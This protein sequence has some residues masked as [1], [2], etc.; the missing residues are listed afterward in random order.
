MDVKQLEYITTI[1]REE[2]ITKAAAK[3]FITQS[4]LNQQLLKL[5]KELGTPLFIRGRNFCYP[6]EAG[7][8]YLKGAREI[9]TIKENTYH[10]LDDLV[11]NRKSLLRVGFTPTRGIDMF[12]KVYPNFH[13]NHVNVTVYP[14]EMSVKEQH[15]GLRS[16]TL[17][18]A[19][20]T[21]TPK[22]YHSSI[23]YQEIMDEEIYLAIPRRHPLA[24]SY[25]EN[26]ENLPTLDLAKVK[27]EPFVLLHQDSTQRPLL[28]ELFAKADF[29]PHILFETSSPRTMISMI[30]MELCC[31]FL[32]AYYVDRKNEKIAYFALPERPHWKVVASYQKQRYLNK[33]AK[34][35]LSLAAKYWHE[36]V[37]I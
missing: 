14:F 3:L 28:D 26:Q 27:E 16:G 13:R 23:A 12:T 2:S 19:F 10:Q 37:T 21:L 34:D 25:Q 22:Q 32:P 17:D 31:G 24:A 9:L 4:A 35:F 33:T 29:T 36:T 1:A 30:E 6:T 20:A 15:E 5:E 8:I 11:D 18:L 7:E